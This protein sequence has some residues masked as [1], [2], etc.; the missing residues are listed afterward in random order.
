MKYEFSKEY[1]YLTD[2]EIDNLCQKAL[3]I[4]LDLSYPFDQSV[5]TIPETRPRAVQWVH[6][7]MQEILERNGTNAKSYSENGLSIMFDS[8]MISNGLRN[9][10]TSLAGTPK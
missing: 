6:D 1:D 2:D 3:G 4:Y 9:R 7:C 5:E 8:S 10:L